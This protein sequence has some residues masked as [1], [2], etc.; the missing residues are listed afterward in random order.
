MQG[1]L[2][3]KPFH[4]CDADIGHQSAASQTDVEIIII[5]NVNGIMFLIR[6]EHFVFLKTAT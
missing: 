1:T 4:A 3:Q 6:M 5:R 2:Q